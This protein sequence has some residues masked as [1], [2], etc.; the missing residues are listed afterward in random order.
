MVGGAVN[1]VGVDHQLRRHAAGGRRNRL[2]D[3][4]RDH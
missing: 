3:H 2:F 1:N 4:G